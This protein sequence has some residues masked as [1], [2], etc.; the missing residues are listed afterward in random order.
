MT[1][2]FEL[3]VNDKQRSVNLNL[4]T[5]LEFNQKDNSADIQ[6]L[7]N[8]QKFITK[9]R[10][11]ID[12]NKVSRRDFRSGRSENLTDFIQDVIYILNTYEEPDFQDVFDILD[13]EIRKYHY[14]GCR[15]YEL[16]ENLDVRK[17]LASKFDLIRAQ[18]IS[19]V[20]GYINMLAV[21]LKEEKY[22]KSVKELMDF[23][24][25]LYRQDSRDKFSKV[26]I[27]LEEFNKQ[28]KKSVS[29]LVKIVRDGVRS[30]IFDHYTDLNPNARR[31]LKTKIEAFLKQYKQQTSSTTPN[32]NKETVK[33]DKSPDV[34][35][36]TTPEPKKPDPN[37]LKPLKKEENLQAAD[38]EP[39]SGIEEEDREDRG[40]KEDYIAEE[41]DEA[42]ESDPVNS[43]YDDTKNDA[44][45]SL[46]DKKE[47]GNMRDGVK[48]SQE[49]NRVWAPMYT[50]G[51][52][53]ENESPEEVKD[54]VTQKQV[55]RSYQKTTKTNYRTGR[56]FSSDE[57]I[58]EDVGTVE[59]N[60]LEF[61]AEEQATTT[62]QRYLFDLCA[63]VVGYV[64]K[65][66]VVGK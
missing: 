26:L 52:S 32:V 37:I 57:K 65:G 27:G 24:N 59:D 58:S 14:R 42:K 29:D 19:V 17:L 62:H 18:P 9:V 10:N 23:I 41:G 36:D 11:V 35:V 6:F 21:I 48:D 53:N 39:R 30:I 20:K 3:N 43:R 25:S 34:I 44:S 49:K 47:S 1:K 13:D 60:S 8:V 55:P 54:D 12:N 7:D 16:T 2:E 28:K 66:R 5:V 40:K 45:E 56:T 51:D 63:I 61:Q 15:F 33:T 31:E 64:N 22:D 38:P 50:K 46:D 4:E